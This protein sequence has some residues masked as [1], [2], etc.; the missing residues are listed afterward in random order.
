MESLQCVTAVPR[1]SGLEL[2]KA[3][4]SSAADLSRLLQH[5]NLAQLQTLRLNAESSNLVT[6]DVLRLVARL[7]Q[8]R[9]LGV[10]LQSAEEVAGAALLQPLVHAP[11][12]TDLTLKR[13]EWVPS[14]AALLSA[15]SQCAGLRQLDLDGVQFPRG[16][17]R[18]FFTSPNMR[19]LQGLVLK[20]IL[21][22]AADTVIDQT[23]DLMTAPDFDEYPASAAFS[24][25][26]QLKSFSLE[27]VYGIDT[28][29]AGLHYAKQLR[30]LCIHCS[31]EL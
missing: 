17:L 9:S 31:G 5:P 21:A 3:P 25:L 4:H 29:L 23:G 24:A 12:L 30:Q 18:S 26:K 19:R 16:S 27:R 11:A 6:V 8:L 20:D 1:L 22:V 7:P 2:M 14:E 13:S 10:T 15:I 28:L